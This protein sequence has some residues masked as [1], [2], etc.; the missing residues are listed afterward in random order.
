M[1]DNLVCTEQLQFNPKTGALWL[2]EIGKQDLNELLT[3]EESHE[4]IMSELFDS[5]YTG[6]WQ[7]IADISYSGHLSCAEAIGILDFTNSGDSYASEL[8]YWDNYQIRSLV[9]ELKRHG[10]AQLTHFVA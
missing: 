8:W 5:Y 1:V 2:T 4:F 3:D 10:M 7:Y 6:E 9:T